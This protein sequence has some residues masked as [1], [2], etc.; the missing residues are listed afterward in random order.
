[1]ALFKFGKT[2]KHQR[3]NYIPRFYDPE[4]EERDARIKAAMGLSDD[5]PEAMK[6]RI[7]RGFR[8]RKRG[9]RTSHQR[10]ARR[11]NLIL[12]ITLITLLMLTYILL[13]RYLPAIERALE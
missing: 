13:T 3:F 1:M 2:V 11:S 10:A 5:S 4:K 7:I 12:V 9:A 6:S 8:D